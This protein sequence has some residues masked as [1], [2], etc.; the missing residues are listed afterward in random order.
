MKKHLRKIQLLIV[1]LLK[2]ILYL[3]VFG[4]FYG[5][6]SI[7]NWQLLVLSRTSAVVLV[8]YV[9]G[10]YMF[11]KIYGG[12]DI[13]KR[14]SKPIII[15][16]SLATAFTDIFGYVMLSIMNVNPSNNT[17]LM[18]E[19]PWL[20]VL[21]F[22]AQVIEIFVMVYGGNAIY[23]KIN[24]PEKS[25]VVTMSQRSLNEI[26]RGI[27]KYKLQ[28]NISKIVDYRDEKLKDYINECD[29]VFLYDVPIESRS[30][31]IEYCYQNMKDIYVN[32][33]MAD[34]SLRSA[35]HVILDDVSM[36]NI[37]S[38]GLSA[39]AKFLKRA[40]DIVVSVIALILSSPLLLIAVIA[41]KM[42]DG[43]SIFFK[44]NRATI[45]GKI[46]SVYKIRTMKEDVPNYAALENDDRITKAGRFLRRFRIDE[47]PQFINVLRGEMSVIGP[48]P[49]ML[50]NVFNITNELPEFEYR[51]RVK[52][53]ITG[54]AQIAG[55]YNTSPRDKL[56]LDLI[57]IEEYSMWLDI[58]LLFQTLI[59][60]FK[61]DSTEGMKQETELLFEEYR[62]LIPEDDNKDTVNNEDS[63]NEDSNNED[64]NNEVEEMK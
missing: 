19:K 31:I 13:G 45:N 35:K 16:I 2:T 21:I 20:I 30:N 18:F 43:G 46:F 33:S 8:S 15:S 32:P 55:K 60:V 23:F 27:R 17:H 58:K 10:G 42:D 11:L 1:F 3:G 44:Q 14:K 34:I 24:S 12:Y 29:T 6:L 49:E 57:Y 62:S 25:L 9:A 56:V 26:V 39:E 4:T 63:N 53:G 61:K 50:G 28:Y 40:F 51:L 38:K 54:Y 52:A 7:E 36:L 47:I 41:V 5:I 64:S 48:R 37:S 22:I 59:V